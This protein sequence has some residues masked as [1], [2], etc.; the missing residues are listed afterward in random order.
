MPTRN[1]D[2]TTGQDASV[3]EETDELKRDRL[4]SLVQ[5]GLDTL[6]NRA[7]TEVDD[8]EIDTMLDGLVATEVG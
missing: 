1:V 6:K 3:E 5:A 7:F 8:T 4:R 2:L